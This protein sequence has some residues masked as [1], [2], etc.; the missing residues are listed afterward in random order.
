[1]ESLDDSEI[2]LCGQEPL[3]SRGRKAPMNRA[4]D[5]GS[6]LW[7][8]ESLGLAVEHWHHEP[9]PN[10]SQEGKLTR[11]GRTLVPFAGGVGTMNRLFVLLL[12]VILLLLSS[13]RVRVRKLQ[14]SPWQALFLAPRSW[15]ENPMT[16]MDTLSP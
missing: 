14:P 9:T 10:P 5:A 1:M 11:R 4:Q 16:T 15:K 7:F 2:V 12:L 3:L 8:M 6:T 13:L